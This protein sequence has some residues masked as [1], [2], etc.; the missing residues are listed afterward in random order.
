VL[1]EHGVPVENQASVLRRASIAC[2]ALPTC[3]LA[4]AESERIMPEVLDRI[5]EVLSELGLEDEEIIIRMTGC[6]N[7][8]A[9]PFSAELGLVGRAPGKYQLYLGGNEAGT[10]LGQLFRQSVKSDDIANE[11]RP[12]LSRFASER[13]GAERF[14]D[15]CQRVLLQEEPAAAASLEAAV[16]SI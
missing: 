2:P 7:G 9:R 15:F 10:R 12:W 13:L 4:L 3:G 14:G 6:P 11:L 5:E 8:C 1:A 16:A